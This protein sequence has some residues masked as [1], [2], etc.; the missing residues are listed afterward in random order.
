MLNCK[1]WV[2]YHFKLLKEIISPRI[3][4][5]CH[6]EIS[7]GYICDICR[8]QYLLN[9]QYFFKPSEEYLA[10]Q[11][12]AKTEDILTNLLMLYKYD[13]IYKDAL[14]QIKFAN[15][16]NL[17]P[18]LKEEAEFALKFLG[19]RWLGQFDFIAC[20]PTSQERYEKRGYDVPQELFVPIISKYN[21]NLY[22]ENLLLRIRST[23]PLFSLS[24]E[25]RKTELIGCFKINAKFNVTKKRILLCDDIFTT[26]STI[27]EAA[28][29][30]LQQGA[31]E[32]S[33]LTFA[34]A[35]MN[36]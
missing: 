23:Q 16:G 36:W 9:K 4:T 3:C 15:K 25:Q 21:K 1:L 27:T 19:E 2:N 11:A 8:K 35:K 5:I 28:Q 26:G 6:N 10:G 33:A 7:Q 24:P 31:S 30:L 18:F 12:E 22:K 13:G 20:I 29:L 32:V 14:H 34:A 17:L